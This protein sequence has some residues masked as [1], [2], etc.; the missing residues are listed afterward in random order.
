MKRS[1]I[2]YTDYCDML[3]TVTA[4]RAGLIIR[5][6]VRYARGEEPDL[7]DDVVAGVFATIKPRMDDD[8]EKWAQEVKRRAEA[9]RK[10][11]LQRARNA[12]QTQGELSSAKQSQAMLSTV[13]QNQANQADIDNDIDIELKEKIDKKE[14]Q[15]AMFER[16]IDGRAVSPKIVDALRDWI[17]YKSERNERYKEVGMK[18]LISQAVNDGASFGSE[19]VSSAI[20][21][22]IASGYKGIV[23]DKLKRRPAA[24]FNN[25]TPRDYNMDELEL[26]LLATN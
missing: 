2:M 1:F 14:T 15:Q 5:A 21:T 22:S 20:Y 18:S 23:W 4:E 25:T 17:T 3:E 11:G 16:L 19:A 8:L 7:S 13:K 6:M 26:K 9:G 24:K 10:G 12:K